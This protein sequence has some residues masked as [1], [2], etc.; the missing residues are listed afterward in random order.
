[1]ATGTPQRPGPGVPLT[2]RIGRLPNL[3]KAMKKV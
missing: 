3:V 2:Q 1:M